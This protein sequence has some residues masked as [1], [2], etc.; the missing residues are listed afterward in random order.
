MIIALSGASPL[1]I[2]AATTTVVWALIVA[3]IL[4]AFVRLLLGPTLADRAVVLD[5]L[6]NLAQG[7]IALYAIAMRQSALLDVSIAIA[8]I[9]FLGTVAFARYIEKGA[10]REREAGR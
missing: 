5:L 9:S 10:R 1:A 6:T 2:A 8:L 7:S 4:I 3:A